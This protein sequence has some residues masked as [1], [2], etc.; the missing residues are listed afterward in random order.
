MERRALGAQ[1]RETHDVAEVNRHVVV[2]LG[3]YGLSQNQLT[4]HGPV[5][6]VQDN[7]T[8][9]VT[10]SFASARAFEACYRYKYF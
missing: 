1:R 6:T 10:Y 5:G 9:N 7:I 4:G 8:V 2:G 3:H